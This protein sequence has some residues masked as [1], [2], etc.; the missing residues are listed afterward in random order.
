MG[1]PL[2]GV[3]I[4]SV[5]HYGAGPFGTG[6]LAALGADIVKIENPH[7]GGDTSRSV[8]P[9]L[10]GDGD[11]EFFQTLNQSKRSLTLDLKRPEGRS[12]LEKLVATADGLMNNLRGDQPAKLRIT[13]PDMKEVNPA[14]VCA[15]LS[16]YGREGSRATWPGY[17]YLMQAETGFMTLTG[18]PDGPPTRMGLSIVDWMTGTTTVLALVS[19]ILK[20][21]ETG[22]GCD[23]D[24]TLFDTALYQTT[25]PAVWNLNEG[26]ITTRLPRSA[27]PSL[28]PSQ[29]YT[30]KDGWVFLMGLTH[31]FWQI[32]CEKTG[33]MDLFDHPDFVDFPARKKNIVAL[34]EILDAVF[35]EKTVEEWV[36][37]FA[38][39]VPIGPVYDLDDALKTDFVRERGM[40]HSYPH[41]VKG[42]LKV[43]ASPI[44]ID[45]ERMTTTR[46]PGLGE[47]TD[48]I[49]REIGLGDDDIAALRDK[50]VV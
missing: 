17:D 25:Y 24:C 31:K 18:E 29:L 41:P 27:H 46:A 50:K 20:A 43:L 11:S 2:E 30:A 19:A 3:R 48:E 9:H 35:A 10:L 22:V 4:V 23:I 45:G 6:H 42:D 36:D 16:A 39:H 40:I 26:E 28:V 14:I 12:V 37:I 15:H 34:N 13:Y 49:L 21:R 32:I 1:R 33:R 7:A 5:E 8:T 38:G 44:K 47:N